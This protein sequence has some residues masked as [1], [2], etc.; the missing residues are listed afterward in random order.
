MPSHSPAPF[1]RSLRALALAV[2][3]AAS[4]LAESQAQSTS[5]QQFHWCKRANGSESGQ[6]TPCDPGTEV[7]ACPYVNG[8]ADCSKTAPRIDLTAPTT[9]ATASSSQSRAATAG[10]S[11]VAKSDEPLKTA[12]D[13]LLRYLAWGLVAGVVFKLLRRSFFLG[14]FAGVLLRVLLVAAALVSF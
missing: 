13:K 14:F 6:L 9:A 10:A 11:V 5:G 2:A 8:L 3:L 4:A 1:V 7:R 12:R